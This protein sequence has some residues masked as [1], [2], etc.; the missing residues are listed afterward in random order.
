MADTSALRTVH[1]IDLEIFRGPIELLVYLVRR[2]ELS[3]CDVPISQ[4]TSQY[5]TF[6]QSLVSLNVA[7]AVEFLI[8]VAVLIRIKTR[9]LLPTRKTEELEVGQTVVSNDLRHEFQQYQHAAELLVQFEE[10]HRQ[11][12]PRWGIDR[13]TLPARGDIL[14]LSEVF[15]TLVSRLLPDDELVMDT[16]KL[17]IAERIN[18]LRTLLAEQCALDFRAYLRTMTT[19]SELVITFLAALE[20]SRTGEIRVSQDELSGAVYILKRT[21]NPSPAPSV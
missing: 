8:L 18:Q 4:I 9:A 20:L 10:R 15:H 7:H 13:G 17:R 6:L 3:V 1:R 19:M 16:V 14:L 2:A 12:F 11:L 5:L 21:E